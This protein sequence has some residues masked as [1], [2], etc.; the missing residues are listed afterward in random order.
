[1]I[2]KNPALPESPYGIH[3][4]VVNGS[5]N[6]QSRF[7]SSVE[8]L[9]WAHGGGMF[10]TGRMKT[11]LVTGKSVCLLR[12]KQIPIPDSSKPAE[13]IM[14]NRE[15]LEDLGLLIAPTPS[16]L[17]IT[18]EQEDLRIDCQYLKAAIAA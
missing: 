9:Y 6:A 7:M 2:I 11:R 10:D 4:S 1:M 14:N 5:L 18:Y 12:G 8:K 3:F 16:L 15:I 13:V 17:P